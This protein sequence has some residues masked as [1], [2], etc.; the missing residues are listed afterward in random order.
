M[1][2]KKKSFSNKG[3]CL[4]KIFVSPFKKF[5]S[6]KKNQSVKQMYSVK[7]ELYFQ[8]SFATNEHV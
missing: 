4:K 3:I 8:F 5:N 1:I 6:V 2:F 7:D